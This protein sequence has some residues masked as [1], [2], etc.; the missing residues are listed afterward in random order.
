[1]SYK[2]LRRKRST[3]NKFKLPKFSDTKVSFRKLFTKIKE[4][5]RFS[6]RHRMKI[7]SP[8]DGQKENMTL[9]HILKLH[10]KPKD[11]GQYRVSAYTVFGRK[12]SRRNR[13]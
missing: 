7:S 1:M 8:S 5:P 6:R 10:R 9:D 2:T 4:H 11:L 12:K 13:K 3:N